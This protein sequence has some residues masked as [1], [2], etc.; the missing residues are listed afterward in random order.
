MKEHLNVLKA[1]P[2]GRLVDALLIE[3]YWKTTGRIGIRLNH[4]FWVRITQVL[5]IN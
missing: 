5:F 3:Y 2:A 1:E 4:L